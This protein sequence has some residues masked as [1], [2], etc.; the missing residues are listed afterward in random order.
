MLRH[1]FIQNYA[2][3]SHL[4]IDLASGFSVITGETGAGKSII[5]GAL[6]L[7]MGGRADT[8]TITEGEDKCIIEAEFDGNSKGETLLIRRELNTNGRSRSFVNDEVIT[9]GELKALATQLIDIHSQHESLLMNDDTFQLGIVDTIAHN[10]AERSEYDRR[11]SAYTQAKDELAKTEAMAK[12]AQA[13]ADYIEFQYNQL[14]EARLEADEEEMLEQEQYCLSHAEDIRMAYQVAV[15]NLNGDGANALSLIH[16]INLADAD[17]SLSERLQSV[18]I[19]LRDIAHEAERQAE[20]VEA[21]PVRLQEID[22]RIALLNSLKK[23]HNVYTV[24]ELISLRNELE[25]Q[26]NRLN[27]FDEEI[28][29]LKQQLSEAKL[30]L[31]TAA[32]ALTKSRQAVIK[33]IATNLI[34]N[35]T[36]L[37]I[38]HP[39]IEV[40]I[41]ALEDFTPC[42]IDDIQFLFAANL[43]QHVRR[44]SEVASGGELSRLMLCIKSL[45]ATTNGLPTI[46][47][48]EIDT[49]VSGEIATQM[50]K[51][52]RK[53]SGARQIIAITHLPQIAAQG[54]TQ[55]KVYKAD[56]AQRTETHIQSL[57][58]E[59]RIEEIASMLSGNTPTE[60]AREN[61]RQ[62]IM[63]IAK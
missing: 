43:N 28:S 2:L 5:L 10:Q 53:M 30:A 1:L 63:D 4:D 22:E 60:A 48:D 16:S 39:Q 7:V 56:T 29:R 61:A 54:A 12:K 37:G 55:Y 47:F 57:T 3:I 6:N 40:E 35:L 33:T 27:S 45:V 11:Y 44:V 50:G 19:E 13:D 18:E 23:K 38:R 52:M 8:K 26:C 20:R 62:L 46:I 36:L 58:A 49:G 15:E 59:E 9:Q 34:H 41:N 51:I 42:G 21:D 14:A 25:Q 17:S 31:Q 24:A 32:V